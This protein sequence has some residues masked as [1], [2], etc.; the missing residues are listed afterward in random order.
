MQVPVYGTFRGAFNNIRSAIVEKLDV[1]H[2]LVDLLL[3]R[4]ILLDSH[5]ADIRVSVGLLNEPFQFQP[6]G[7]LLMCVMWQVLHSVLQNPPGFWCGEY[8]PCLKK[9]CKLIFCSLSVKYKA[10]SIKIGRTVLE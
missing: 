7:I 5:V 4:G 10:I 8:T 1:S 9:L 6:D 2:G 3:Q